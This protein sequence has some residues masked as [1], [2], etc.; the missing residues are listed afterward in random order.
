MCS[1]GPFRYDDRENIIVL[2][3]IIIIKSKVSI[4]PIVVILPMSCVSVRCF[5]YIPVKLIF[6]TIVHFMMWANNGVHYGPKVVFACF[7]ITSSHY[8]FCAEL[9]ESTEY[10]KCFSATLSNLNLLLS[11]FFQLS[12]MRHMGLCVISFPVSLL[13]IA[14]IVVLYLIIIM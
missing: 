8:H 3:L 11:C 12:S 6:I 9:P 5:I 2:H 10:V 7:H 14:S 13:M 4:F 1:T